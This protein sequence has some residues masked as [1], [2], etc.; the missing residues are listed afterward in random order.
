MSRKLGRGDR[1][2]PIVREPEDKEL[3]A[4][5]FAAAFNNRKCR[6]VLDDLSDLEERA[7]STLERTARDKFKSAAKF[8][9]MAE[10]HQFDKKRECAENV[11]AYVNFARGAI[12]RG[13]IM[14]AARLAMHAGIQAERIFLHHW[15]TLAKVGEAQLRSNAEQGKYTEEEKQGWEDLAE[16]L[17]ND[18]SLPKKKKSQRSLA[19][20]VSENP[21]S[22]AGFDA[23]RTHFQ[24]ENI[25]GKWQ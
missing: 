5:E 6:T 15:E 11:I 8:K 14:E 9:L 24:E 23:V 7:R 12:Q 20:L 17:F 10:Y 19:K 4:E 3:S 16:S 22:Q 1:Y 2:D 18:P 21:D 25:P 13:N